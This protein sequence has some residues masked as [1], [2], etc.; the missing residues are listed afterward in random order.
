[1][2]IRMAMVTPALAPGRLAPAGSRPERGA[3]VVTIGKADFVI[4]GA[5]LG[6][7]E[8]FVNGTL[9]SKTMPAVLR[10]IVFPHS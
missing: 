5:I 8:M 4:M 1:M 7:G 9:Q 10:K 3:S 6:G 2:S